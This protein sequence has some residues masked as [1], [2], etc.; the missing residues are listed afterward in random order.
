M[1]ILIGLLSPVL[2]MPTITGYMATSHGRSFWRWFGIGCVLP[3]FS[4][5]LI[6]FV[7]Y[8][9]QRRARLNQ[10]DTSNPDLP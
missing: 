4:L 7:V 1:E 2:F 5:P 9:D 10:S 6:T 3:Y 8:R